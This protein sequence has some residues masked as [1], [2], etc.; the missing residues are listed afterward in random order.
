MTTLLT[1]AP[2]LPVRTDGDARWR[3]LLT[4][5]WAIA[6]ALPADLVA[7]A[8]RLGLAATFWISGQTKIQDLVI[9]PIGGRLQLRWPRLSDSAVDLFRYEY[10]LPLLDP[11]WAAGLAAGAEHLLPLLLV[12]GLATRWAALGLLAMTAVIQL[13]VYPL[14]WPV[15]LTWLAA[16]LYLVVHGPGRLSVDAALRRQPANG[17]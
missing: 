6:R 8:A 15:H 12:L 11:A 13:F 5:P 17:H 4:G 16:L 2:T 3:R 1:N 9:D 10:N 14:A 7:V